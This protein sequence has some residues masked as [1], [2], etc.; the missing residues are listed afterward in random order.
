MEA[1]MAKTILILIDACGDEA[2][3]EQAGYIEHLVDIKKAAR[4]T[5]R[6]GLPSV[7]R[8]M[9]ESM[10]TGLD[11]TVH[12]VLNNAYKRPSNFESLF[13]LT[14]EQGKTNAAAAYGWV[15]EL[16]N[17]NGPFS[18]ANHR[19]QLNSK[20]DIQQGIFY[21]EDDYP[22]SHLIMDGEMLRQMYHPDFLFMHSM[23]V[24]LK[25]HRF[26]SD[27]KEYRAAVSIV[28]DV[29]TSM[30]DTWLA[31][32][33]DIVITADHGMDE[34]G[35][36]GGTSDIQRNVPL[37]IISDKVKKGRFTKKEISNLNIAPLVCN[38]MGISPAEGMM[39]SLEVEL[40]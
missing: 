10:L 16:Y 20:G 26:G 25:G 13:S 19:I 3:K 39:N 35:M 29:I 9:Y 14:K 17:K 7:S 2:A 24:D 36:H 30:V 40:A 4:Y 11:A 38:L 15:S 22:D 27:S 6:G 32:G 28:F 23:N 21:S 5:V 18:L 34:W 33:Y 31:D 8:P 12:G 1:K 37:Y